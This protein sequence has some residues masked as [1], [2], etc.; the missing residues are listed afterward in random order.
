MVPVER[1]SVPLAAFLVGVEETRGV[2][3]RVRRLLEIASHGYLRRAPI[4]RL[5]ASFP[6]RP[7]GVCSCSVL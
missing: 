3:A 5:P 4:P 2:K 1:A 6:L 7:F